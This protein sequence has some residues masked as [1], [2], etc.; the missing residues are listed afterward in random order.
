MLISE[1]GS[2]EEKS[3]AAMTGQNIAWISLCLLSNDCIS[4]HSGVFLLK[5]N[6]YH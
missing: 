3:Q 4:Q 2:K 6:Y 5:K 1:L